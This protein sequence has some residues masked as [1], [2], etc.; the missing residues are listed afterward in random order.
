MI[1][2]QGWPQTVNA[3]E[4]ASEKSISAA[5]IDS[6]VETLKNP[7]ARE[8]LINELQ[9]LA[10][11]REVSVKKPEVRSAMGDILRGISNR[12][13]TM[14]A[15][16]L[17]VTEGINQLP[18]TVSW[19]REQ[20]DNPEARAFWG[21]VVTRMLLVLGFGYAAF[22]LTGIL[23]KRPR[24]SVIARKEVSGSYLYRVFRLLGVFVLDL[25]PIAAF[26]AAAYVTLGLVDPREKTRLVVL[27]WIN[28]FILVRLIVA[29]SGSLLASGSPNLRL[30]PVTDETAHYIG[31]WVSR[32]S[33]VAAYG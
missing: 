10:Q 23:L 16:V 11:A 31:I 8:K 22:Y 28:A 30:W 24:S 25:L 12:V 2:V 19:F 13:K 3:Q 15:A 17:E 26:A 14:T 18:Q 7:E 1:V 32:L 27:A 4:T 6:I 33:R 5:E 20:V 21:E 29:I 9:L